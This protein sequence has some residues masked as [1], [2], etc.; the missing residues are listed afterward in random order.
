MHKKL[1]NNSSKLTKKKNKM[2][3]TETAKYNLKEGDG[4]LILPGQTIVHT[5]DKEEPWDLCWVA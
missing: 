3:K 5:A 4:F 2:K 1:R